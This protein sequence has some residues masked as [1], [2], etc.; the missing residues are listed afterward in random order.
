MPE[1]GNCGVIGSVNSQP[2]SAAAGAGALDSAQVGAAAAARDAAL[3]W[4]WQ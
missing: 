2:R 1:D 4:E 3:Q